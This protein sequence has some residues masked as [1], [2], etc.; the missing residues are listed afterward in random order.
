[1]NKSLSLA[2]IETI[3]KWR[4]NRGQPS[5]KKLYKIAEFFKMPVCNFLVTRTWE[6]GASKAELLKIEKE[7]SKKNKNH[8][9][10]SK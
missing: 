7:E 3:S 1:L 9:K 6:P 5:L 2:T 10:S 8:K 4:T